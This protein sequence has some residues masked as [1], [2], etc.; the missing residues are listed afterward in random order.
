[1]FCVNFACWK[2]SFEQKGPFDDLAFVV[3]GRLVHSNKG[4]ITYISPV[5][6]TMFNG[7]FK[8]AHSDQ[9]PITQTSAEDFVTFMRAVAPFRDRVSDATVQVL[10]GLADVYDVEFLRQD[11]EKHLIAT[12]GIEA[13][14]KLLLAQSLSKTDFI[15]HLV[16]TLRQ[17]DLKKIQNDKRKEELSAEVKDQLREREKLVL[18]D[19][20]SSGLSF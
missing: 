5:M 10:Y 9:V 14:D 1:M 8:E 11:C 12:R 2:D 16:G 13:I 6:H 17:A 15:A 4:Y 18:E 20:H 3:E 19:E 7:N